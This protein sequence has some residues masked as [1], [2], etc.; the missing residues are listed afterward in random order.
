MR[1]AEILDEYGAKA[2]FFLI[3]DRSL[4]KPSYIRESQIRELRQRGFSL[5]THGTTHRKLT[6]LPE[7]ALGE[8]LRGSKE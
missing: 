8:E 3:R 7:Q 5:G 6:F 2:T 1:A 4:Q